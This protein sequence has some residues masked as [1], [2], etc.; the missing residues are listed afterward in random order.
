MLS[1]PAL[2]HVNRVPN[3]L[4]NLAQIVLLPKLRVAQAN[5]PPDGSGEADS[6]TKPGCGFEKASRCLRIDLPVV[7]LVPCF[8]YACDV[9]DHP[10]I[11]QDA[12]QVLGCAKITDRN[13][14]REVLEPF[15]FTCRTNE[16]SHLFPLFDEVLD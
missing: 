5:F 2:D 4:L 16:T 6:L 3:C 13:L 8:G 12:S 14:D 10:N 15:G 7:P 11:A 1:G 9:I